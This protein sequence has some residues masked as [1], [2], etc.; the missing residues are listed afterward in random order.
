[1]IRINA[2]ANYDQNAAIY[3][4]RTSPLM[5]ERPVCSCLQMTIVV[6]VVSPPFHGHSPPIPQ[7]LCAHRELEI[8]GVETR[9]IERT[10]NPA[11]WLIEFA[12]CLGAQD[13]APYFRTKSFD[14][15]ENDGRA[16]RTA[17]Q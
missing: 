4:Y 14:A 6:V 5:R 15:A 16:S 17:R 13:A 9:S 11:Q 1:M 8:A 7:Y 12:S 10:E 3:N 2:L